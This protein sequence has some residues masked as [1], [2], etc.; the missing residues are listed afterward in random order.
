MLSTDSNE[1]KERNM[2]KKT[3]YLTTP[4]V[5]FKVPVVKY[6]RNKEIFNAA[7][8]DRK[9]LNKLKLHDFK[10]IEQR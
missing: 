9:K 10:P 1:S 7:L 3:K 2:F 8:K 4:I 6:Y 5:M